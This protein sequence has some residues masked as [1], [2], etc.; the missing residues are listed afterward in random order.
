[1]WQKLVAVWVQKAVGMAGNAGVMDMSAFNPNFPDARST[2]CQDIVLRGKNFKTAD[3]RTEE[4]GD[5]VMTGAYVPFG[6]ETEPGEVIQ[7][8]TLCGGG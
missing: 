4:E 7:G 5:S 3:F 1:M 8:V 6:A 2:P